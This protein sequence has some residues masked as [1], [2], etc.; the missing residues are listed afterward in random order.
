MNDNPSNADN[1]TQSVSPTALLESLKQFQE[2]LKRLTPVLYGSQVAM[3]KLVNYYY[4]LH[5]DD[6]RYDNPHWPFE[7]REL[8]GA[9]DKV[10]MLYNDKIHIINMGG[11][12]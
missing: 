4:T 11:G 7:L 8:Y 2:T 1:N 9:G 3:M 10:M 6:R 5:P 12:K